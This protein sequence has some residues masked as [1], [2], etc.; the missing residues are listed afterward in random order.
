MN[1]T[2][3]NAETVAIKK[4]PNRRYYDSSHSRH[5]TLED[6]HRMIRAGLRVEVTDSKTG[7]DITS[8][9]LAQ[10]I[11]EMDSLKLGLFPSPLLHKLIQSNDA[12]VHEFVELYFNQALEWFLSSR[13]AFE[14]HFRQ[15]MGLASRGAD[16]P[17][18][19]PWPPTPITTARP[20]AN[21]PRRDP[22]RPSDATKRL[23]ERV[24]QLDK[25]V[26]A[27]HARLQPTGHDRP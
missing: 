21:T 9:V 5:V 27:L 6:I 4:Y 19:A 8:R 18:P 23:H 7:E 17:A 1:N 10:I 24:D 3:P 15:A 12:I 26:E 2:T 25:R 11:L 13:E 14:N 16:E 20:S 22:A